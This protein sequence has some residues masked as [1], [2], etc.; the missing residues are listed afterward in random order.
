MTIIDNDIIP[1]KSTYADD[2]KVLRVVSINVNGLRASEKK[3]LF[4]WLATSDADVVCMQETRINPE[5]W[6]DKFKPTGWHTHLFPAQK[7]G[8][9]GTA[10]YSRLPIKSVKTGLG[11]DIADTQGRFICATFDFGIG[12]DV[13]IASLYLPSGSSGDDAQARKDVFL[14]EYAKI[15]KQWRDD[16]QSMIICGD[17]N[18]VHKRIDIK[19]W[20]GN[21]KASG[22]LPHERAWLDHIYDELG[23]IDSFRAVRDEPFLYSWW[24]N[25]GQARAK[26]VGWRIDYH[27]CTPDWQDKIVGAWVYKDAWFS[28]HAPV[29]VDYRLSID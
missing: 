12:V 11:F 29:V 14:Q 16:N 9:A 17:Y 20:S 18:I 5:Q 22:C 24:S 4:D 8:Y 26:N 10:I 28:D 13:N 3:G 21:Q 27:V 19:N 2:K 1:K 6:T 15:L 7:A 23:Y 25:R